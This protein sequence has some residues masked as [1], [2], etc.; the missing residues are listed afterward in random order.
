MKIQMKY[1]AFTILELI[2]TISLIA[3]I[4]A[5]ISI[6]IF[7]HFTTTALGSVINNISLLAAKARYISVE[8]NMPVYLVFDSGNALVSLSWAS[9]EGDSNIKDGFLGTGAGYYMPEDISFSRITINGITN[10]TQ[11]KKIF[12]PNGSGDFAE[13]TINCAGEDFVLVLTPLFV[14][15]S[16]PVPVSGQFKRVFDLDSSEMSS[17]NI[18]KSW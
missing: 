2:L 16:T 14:D 1:R 18:F 6:T 13:I 17:G 7:R 10:M 4:A 15:I 9:S 11:S 12:R 3:L 8:Y 5:P